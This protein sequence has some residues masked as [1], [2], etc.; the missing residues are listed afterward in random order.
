MA[1]DFPRFMRLPE[2]IRRMIWREAIPPDADMLIPFEPFRA[3]GRPAEAYPVPLPV[4]T[5]L[6]PATSESHA[7]AQEWMR[8]RGTRRDPTTRL[9]SRP[10][11][12]AGDMLYVPRET[13]NE[14]DKMAFDI[15][16][17]GETEGEESVLAQVRFL[18]LPA[19]TAYYS[20]EWLVSVA[21]VM[22]RL[23]KV[24]VV[25]G[26]LPS[27]KEAGKMNCWR[28]VEIPLEEG[29]D[30]DEE[31]D[32]E[33]GG[34][35]TDSEEGYAR[36]PKVSMCHEDPRSGKVFMEEGKLEMWMDEIDMQLSITEVGDIFASRFVDEDQATITLGFVP[37]RMEQWNGGV[38]EQC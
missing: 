37:V 12:W 38:W 29:S 36:G 27:W 35:D 10:V 14:M 7:V 1:T 3:G 19:F 21:E 11:D 6:L 20:H 28:A 4:P 5:A 2:E 24:Y 25:W 18:A 22:P 23:E 15:L 30:G 34:E 13:K 9:V 16:V 32:D 26:V 31:E 33:D 8:S 17:N